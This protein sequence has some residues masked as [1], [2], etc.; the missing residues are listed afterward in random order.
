M[1]NKPTI[2]THMLTKNMHIFLFSASQKPKYLILFWLGKSGNP[3]V[4]DFKEVKLYNLGYNNRPEIDVYKYK[5]IPKTQYTECVSIFVK[6]KKNCF[7]F[8]CLSSGMN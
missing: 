6:K 4:G 5:S 3:K 7:S 2:Q 8:K 1:T